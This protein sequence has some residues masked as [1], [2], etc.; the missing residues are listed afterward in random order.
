MLHSGII[1]ASS[2]NEKADLPIIF[3]DLPLCCWSSPMNNYH[4]LSA[5]LANLSHSLWCH[6]FLGWQWWQ[7]MEPP[8]SSRQ[9]SHHLQSISPSLIMFDWFGFPLQVVHFQLLQCTSMSVFGSPTHQP[10]NF[11]VVWICWDSHIPGNIGKDYVHSIRYWHI[12]TYTYIYTYIH[13]YMYIYM[14]IYI[15]I[16]E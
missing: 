15:V 2:I 7:C 8:F 11:L 6:H 13:I 12:H 5:A 1:Q 3:G 14:Y 16:W 10:P 9:F 4:Q